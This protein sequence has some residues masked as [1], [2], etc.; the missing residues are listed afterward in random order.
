MKREIKAKDN[1]TYTYEAC[2][3]P[4]ISKNNTPVAEY[5]YILDDDGSR[6]VF[7]TANCVRP[8]GHEGACKPTIP[9]Q[10]YKAIATAPSTKEKK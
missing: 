10:D 5:G 9:F 4:V 3:L 6:D 8:S 1:R 7:S 2:W